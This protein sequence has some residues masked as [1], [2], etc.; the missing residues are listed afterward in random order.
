[1][2]VRFFPHPNRQRHVDAATRYDDVGVFDTFIEQRPDVSRQPDIVERQL[3]RFAHANVCQLDRETR[4]KT[5]ACRA[6]RT[7][8]PSQEVA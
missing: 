5:A 7:G 2:A 6:V 3:H 4:K 1:M 8:C